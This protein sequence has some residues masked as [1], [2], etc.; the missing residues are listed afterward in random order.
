MITKLVIKDTKD[1]PLSYVFEVFKNSKEFNFVPGINIIIGKNGSGKSTIL[2]LLSLYSLCYDHIESNITELNNTKLY[3]D[4]FSL[5]KKPT[6]HKGIEV[7]GDYKYPV[8]NLKSMTD[9]DTYGQTLGLQSGIHGFRNMF[10]CMNSSAGE[11]NLLGIDFI[12]NQMNNSDLKFPDTNLFDDWKI[13]CDNKLTWLMDEPDKNLDIYN[14]KE[15]FPILSEPH[16]DIQIIAVIHNP[17]LIYKLSKI[18]NINWIETSKNYLKNL[19]K[20]LL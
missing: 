10:N 14:L 18:D 19:E 9:K 8:F 12:L 6:L 2:K 4:Y 1:S 7:W 15:I 5:N 16:R 11:S 13:E 17:L 20:E 3:N